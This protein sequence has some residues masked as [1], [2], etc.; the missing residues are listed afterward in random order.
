MFIH[1]RCKKAVLTH[2]EVGIGSS[3]LG[4][5][6]TLGSVRGV[7]GCQKTG[8]ATKAKLVNRRSQRRSGCTEFDRGTRIGLLTPRIQ[9]RAAVTLTGDVETSVGSG[10][11]GP[12]VDIGGIRQLC[13]DRAAEQGRRCKITLSS[14]R[15]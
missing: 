2:H 10:R 7:Y 11:E 3:R 5:R 15:S 12:C 14:Q 9:G 4:E 13:D 8:W 6:G 1:L